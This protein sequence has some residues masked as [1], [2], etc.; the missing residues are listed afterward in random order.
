MK[1]TYRVAK[2]RKVVSTPDKS[3]VILSHEVGQEC[4]LADQ[5][6][7]NHIGRKQSVAIAKA[8]PLL[9]LKSPGL[10][11]IQNKKLSFPFSSSFFK[12][13]QF[14]AIFRNEI[15][16]ILTPSTSDVF[17]FGGPWLRIRNVL[18]IYTSLWR[19]AFNAPRGSAPMARY[20]DLQLRSSLRSLRLR[21]SQR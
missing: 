4:S 17:H 21:H 7:E 2:E 8:K 5:E 15:T 3:S 20:Y 13:F 18:Y 6:L 19:R 9:V 16:T 1:V 11:I 12:N 10:A 14:L